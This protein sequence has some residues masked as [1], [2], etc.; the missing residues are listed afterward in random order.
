MGRTR[1]SSL[2]SGL[3]PGDRRAGW[4]RP[5]PDCSFYLDFCEFAVPLRTRA[6]GLQTVC[7]CRQRC[8]N[9]MPHSWEPRHCSWLTQASFW[10]TKPQL[11]QRLQEVG[12]S[13]TLVIRV[14]MYW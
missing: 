4:S 5:I 7:R 14:E 11:S 10:A 8:R 12:S 2:T 1:L 6:F 9:P 3:G 13:V